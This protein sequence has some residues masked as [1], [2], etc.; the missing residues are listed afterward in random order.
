[1]KPSK[2]IQFAR[3]FDEMLADKN[4]SHIYFFAYTAT[5]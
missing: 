3:F 4:I 5:N 1:M 2:M